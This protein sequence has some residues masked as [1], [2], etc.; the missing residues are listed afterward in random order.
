[1]SSILCLWKYSNYQ[2]DLKNNSIETIPAF[3][4]KQSRL[5]SIPQIGERAYIVTYNLKR[6][7]LI[8]RITIGKKGFNPPGYPY[9]KY[10]IIGDSTDSKWYKYGL[11]DIT[12]LIHKLNFNSGGKIPLNAPY[13]I[14]V[15]LQTFRELTAKDVYLL[16]S[17]IPR[18]T[19]LERNPKWTRDEL[20]LALE[21][22]FRVNPVHTNEKNPEIIELSKLLNRL[23]IYTQSERGD[24]FRNPDGVYMKLCNFLRFD[25]D[26]KGKGLDAGSKLEEQVW[27]EFYSN[28]NHL[29]ET[30]SAIKR[31]YIYVTPTHP[32]I[33]ESEFED[34]EFPEGRILSRLHRQKE[35]NPA[36][37]NKK[38]AQILSSTGRLACE[39]CGFD[40]VEFYGDIG[41]GFAECHHKI[42]LSEISGEHS[43][44]LSELSIVCSNCHSMIHKAR[45]TISDL[46]E[47]LTSIGKLISQN[48]VN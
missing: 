3:N 40:F 18:K 8:G 21:L 29:I 32:A 27:D 5:H 34:E 38:K 12:N 41:Q 43:I 28:R 4:S 26:Y 6:C 20:I 25:P 22:Y 10:K 39:A 35:R 15:Y 24:N 2:N 47:I 17:S 45:L 9:G 19:D 14:A 16:E 30:A 11:I 23:P 13:P 1:M 37:V 46:Q 36:L 44:K 31:N 42:P 33:D 7:Y 48:Q